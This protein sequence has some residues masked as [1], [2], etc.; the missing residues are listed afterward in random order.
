MSYDIVR[1]STQYLSVQGNVVVPINQDLT[2]AA[3]V[4]LDDLNTG[5]FVSNYHL[6]LIHI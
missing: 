4:K 2:F 3:W 6:S 5:N 1:A